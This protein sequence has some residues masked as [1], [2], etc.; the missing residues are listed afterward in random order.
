MQLLH[1]IPTSSVVCL[2]TFHPIEESSNPFEF[3]VLLA[4]AYCLGV[5]AEVNVGILGI[6]SFV[7]STFAAVEKGCVRSRKHAASNAK[8]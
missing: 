2:H 3:P 4:R 6:A 1:V 8:K 7:C 5:T